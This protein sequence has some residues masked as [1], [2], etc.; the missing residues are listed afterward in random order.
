MAEISAL[1][2]VREPMVDKQ[3]LVREPWRIWFR[4]QA[5]TVNNQPVLT[6]PAVVLEGKSASVPITAFNT[7]T[8]AKGVYRVS[9][10][11]TCATPAGTSSGFSV[12]VSWTDHGVAQSRTSA[13]MTGNTTTTTQ[14]EIWPIHID[15]GGPVS[16]TLTYA[17][18]PA[19][20]AIFNAYLVLETVA[21]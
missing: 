18:T 7:G 19:S 5:Q 20:A 15:A 17:S 2:P 9:Y 13:N 12:T 8:L 4:D 21:V 3:G 11:M 1:F 10:Y 6:N 14:S 16:Y